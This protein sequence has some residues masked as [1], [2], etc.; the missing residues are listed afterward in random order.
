MRTSGTEPGEYESRVT[1][2]DV[3]IPVTLSVLDVTPRRPED[4]FY[5]VWGNPTRPAAVIAGS[6]Y[7]NREACYWRDSG[8]NVV[9]AYPLDDNPGLNALKERIPDL[10]FLFVLSGK[11]MHLGYNGQLSGADYNDENRAEII[12]ELR[13]KR[14]ELLA[15][16]YGYDRWAVELWDEPGPG[17]GVTLMEKI[18]R[19]I[20]E[21]DPRVQIYCNPW[22]Q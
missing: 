9:H 13:K 15:A 10:K 16:G 21:F 6:D 20:K 17:V 4:Y 3:E 12:E 1:F 8:Y 2:G 14:D 11:Y 22:V 19:T 18:V 7:S 5:T